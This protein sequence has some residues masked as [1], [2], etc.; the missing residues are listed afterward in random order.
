MGAE[1]DCFFKQDIWQSGTVL[2]LSGSILIT[3]ARQTGAILQT[4]LTENQQH[5]PTPDLQPLHSTE[6]EYTKTGFALHFSGALGYLLLLLLAFFLFFVASFPVTLLY[7]YKKA[8]QVV[9][10][11]GRIASGPQNAQHTHTHS[12]SL[13]QCLLQAGRVG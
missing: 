4:G 12:L 2:S 11:A 5:P 6:T 10:K 7:Q 9:C 1:T 3:T 8:S 13:H